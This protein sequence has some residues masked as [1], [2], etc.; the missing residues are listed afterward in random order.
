LGLT[1]IRL[2]AGF[3][4]G[5]CRGAVGPQLVYKTARYLGHFAFTGLLLDRVLAVPGSRV[6]TVSSMGHRI[7]RIRFDDLQ[8][9]HGYSRLG[10]YGQS[11]LAN[12]LFTYELQRRLGPR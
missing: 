6:V 9:K 2:I 8:W 5:R 11:K 4:R 10:A 12:L 3:G 1:G 7:G